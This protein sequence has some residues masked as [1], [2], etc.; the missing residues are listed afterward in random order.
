NIVDEIQ[1]EEAVEAKKENT[2][3]LKIE[4][5]DGAKKMQGKE[6]RELSAGEGEEIVVSG[7]LVSDEKNFDLNLVSLTDLREHHNELSTTVLRER[8]T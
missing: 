7:I 5:I 8:Q 3:A 2:H 6:E 1:R 4:G